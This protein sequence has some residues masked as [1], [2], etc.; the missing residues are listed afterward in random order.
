MAPVTLIFLS[1]QKR[2]HEESPSVSWAA[3]LMS[4]PISDTA[5][6]LPCHHF[7]GKLLPLEL[8]LKP[9]ESPARG[10]RETKHLPVSKGK[11]KDDLQWKCHLKITDLP[12]LFR[13]IKVYLPKS[14]SKVS[15]HFSPL[16]LKSNCP[17]PLQFKWV[18]NN[19][20]Q[21]WGR[22]S[23]TPA[24]LMGEII[25]WHRL[26]SSDEKK[27]AVTTWIMAGFLFFYGSTLTL[28]SRSPSELLRKEK[29]QV[30]K[31]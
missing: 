10:W 29:W 31:Q 26:S 21:S 23:L 24:S 11:K 27:K 16:H 13:Q 8:C 15:F 9:W 18:K 3:L 12:H 30:K 14:S 20:S 19:L 25:A 28:A 1:P 22:T 17:T 6:I 5:E 7:H 4:N 2:W